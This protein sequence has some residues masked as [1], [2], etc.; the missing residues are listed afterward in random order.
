MN[1]THLALLAALA[2]APAAAFADDPAAVP[3]APVVS[4]ATSDADAAALAGK[5]ESATERLNELSATVD[6]L[7]KVK[8][9]GYIQSRWAWNQGATYEP[10]C[11]DAAACT[12]AEL[13]KYTPPDRTNFFIRRGRF[14]VTYEGDISQYV[15]QTDVTPAG[16]S[17]KEGY[18]S[19]KLPYGLA[20]DAG[21]QLFPFGY[22][23]A[24]RSSADLDLLERGM[25]TQSL[26]KGEYDLGVA[27]RGAYGKYNF[28]VG[29]FNGNGID[30]KTGG[31]DNDQRKDVIGRV[32]F[33]FG[34][35]TGGVSGWYGKLIDY[36]TG[37]N[38]EYDRVR[39]GADAQLYLDLLPIGGTAIK[40]EYIWGRTAI[41]GG[42]ASANKGFGA[43]DSLGKT[44]GGGYLLATQN[45][46][47]TFQVAA[48]YDTFIPDQGINHD[49]TANAAKVFQKNELSGAVHAYFGEAFKLT[50]AYYH[51][52]NGA[53]GS[54]AVDPKA[55]SVVA[56]AQVKF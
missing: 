27:V 18:A 44:M 42:S 15:L 8:F 3:V 16:V 10:K 11:V 45:V 31:R 54:A 52:F 9:S 33:D 2:I 24:S 26:L 49:L 19:V 35:L 22:E 56:Q 37:G 48:R 13:A 17:I 1:A 40:A 53:A 39:L 23:V 34:M 5:I 32:G 7:K 12:D 55:D 36:T 25:M 38:L 20:V 30:S 41:G 4:Q 29:L 46:G 47:K 43:G 50:L 14:K 21:L 6:A 51:P 28:K